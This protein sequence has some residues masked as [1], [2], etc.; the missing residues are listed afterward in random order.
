MHEKSLFEKTPM[1]SYSV[2]A[3]LSHETHRHLLVNNLQLYTYIRMLEALYIYMCVFPE[4][5]DHR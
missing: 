4:R 5:L 3:V 1:K 2:T